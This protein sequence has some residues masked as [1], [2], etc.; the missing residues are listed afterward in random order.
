MTIGMSHCDCAKASNE[1]RCSHVLAIACV[2][3]LTTCFYVNTGGTLI[4]AILFYAAQ[5]LFVIMNEGI[6]LIAAT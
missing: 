5:N 3:A 2:S 1:N 6:P 4:L